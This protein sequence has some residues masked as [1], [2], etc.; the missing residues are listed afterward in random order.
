[1]ELTPSFKIF[2]FQIFTNTNYLC[3]C[4]ERNKDLLAKAK[5]KLGQERS[6]I[7]DLEEKI[8]KLMQ[9]LGMKV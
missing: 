7:S 8:Q 2:C 9:H 6:T 4:R 1:M 3:V 5:E